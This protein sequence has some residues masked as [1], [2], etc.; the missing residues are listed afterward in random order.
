[1][2]STTPSPCQP[3]LKMI[4]VAS[5]LHLGENVD[6]E[7]SSFG[8]VPYVIVFL[9]PSLTS[10]LHFP[11]YSLIAMC[12]LCA[13]LQYNHLLESETT[14]H[15]DYSILFWSRSQDVLQ[16]VLFDELT[17][18]YDPFCYPSYLVTFSLDIGFQRLR[19]LRPPPHIQC[20]QTFRDLVGRYHY[21]SKNLCIRHVYCLTRK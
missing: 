20:Q 7:N 1:M 3:A 18:P 21:A 10:G 15:L 12:K 6:T 8:W 11:S 13:Q 9:V 5:N 19:E 2:Q 17:N 4:I 16:K 14:S